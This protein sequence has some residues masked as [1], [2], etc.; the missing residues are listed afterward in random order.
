[1]ETIRG[2][3]DAMRHFAQARRKEIVRL[4]DTE[5]GVMEV[6]NWGELPMTKKVREAFKTF[7][8]KLLRRLK[9]GAIGERQWS[10]PEGRA[11]AI[12]LEYS[13]LLE[14]ILSQA[15]KQLLLIQRKRQEKGN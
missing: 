10:E 13:G 8:G 2:Q 1:M 11:L 15:Q 9:K 4:V 5:Q 6:I 3:A 7:E 14:D 12:M